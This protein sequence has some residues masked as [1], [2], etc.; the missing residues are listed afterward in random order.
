MRTEL[1]VKAALTALEYHLPDRRL[2]NADL[3][4]QFGPEIMEQVTKLT[5]V[6]ERRVAEPAECGSDLAAAAARK[7]FASAG[8]DPSEIDFLLYCTAGPDFCLPATACL[9]QDR[10]GL[11][12]RAGALDFNLGCSGYIYGL[13]LAKGLIE[14][15]QAQRVLLLTGDTPSKVVDPADRSVRPLFGDAGS[16][17]LIESRTTTLENETEPLIGPFV[18]GTDGTGAEDLMVAAGGFRALAQVPRDGDAFAPCSQTMRLH[19]NG[20][21]VY[22]FMRQ[23]VP[24]LL[25]ELLEKSGL[26]QDEIDIFVFHQASKL[27]LERLRRALQIPPEAFCVCIKDVGNTVS[28]TIPITLKRMEEEG[29]MKPGA[30]LALAGFGVGFSWG[31]TLVRW[32]GLFGQ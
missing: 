4:E 28:S 8:M 11:S 21:G 13:S 32:K 3:C 15:G 1:P 17:S 20:T 31:A 30:R 24:A 23:T 29:R 10:L 26:T 12:T 16:A 19:M 9:L 6:E 25:H 18:F 2:T 5:G 14:T 22:D 27:I 7:L